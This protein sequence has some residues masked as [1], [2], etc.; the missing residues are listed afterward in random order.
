M[1]QD[2]GAEAMD[3]DTQKA[4]FVSSL[5]EERD[6]D[7]EAGAQFATQDG[8]KAPRAC[9]PPI[10]LEAPILTLSGAREP[11]PRPSEHKTRTS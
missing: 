3:V 6:S 9:G 7:D 4:K 10:E 5:E 2:G 11:Q 1:W 8:K